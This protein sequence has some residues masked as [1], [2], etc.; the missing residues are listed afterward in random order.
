MTSP[1]FDAEPHQVR[2][3]VGNA[4]D[5]VGA[6]AMKRGGRRLAAVALTVLLLV[7]WRHVYCVTCAGYTYLWWL[8]PS[9]EWA[10]PDDVGADEQAN[11]P[12]PAIIHQTWQTNQVP[13]KWK[14]AQQSCIDMHPDYEYRL[15]TDD[16]GLQLIKVRLPSS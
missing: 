2:P 5:A 1:Q 12:V 14:E 6:A 16:D 15:W 3:G 13:D 10:L 7:S 4:L 8:R 11:L 9:V